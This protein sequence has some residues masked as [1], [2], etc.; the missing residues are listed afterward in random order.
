VL[1]LQHDY[2]GEERKGMDW[3][4]LEG[5]GLEWRGK[6]R[7]GFMKITIIAKNEKG[8]LALQQH[9]KECVKLGKVQ[10]FAL[11]QLGYSQEVICDDP[12]TLQIYSKP[13]SIFSLAKPKHIIQEIDE[14]MKKNGADILTDYEI[15]EGDIE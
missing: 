11:R 13:G 4:G 1:N 8:T 3:N 5:R 10:R 12:L 14:A 15:K 2:N 7:N 9:I 6:E